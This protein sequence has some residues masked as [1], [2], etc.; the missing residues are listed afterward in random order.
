MQLV[1]DP[2]PDPLL[3]PAPEAVV[4]GRRRAV[5]AGDVV[6]GDAGAQHIEDAV[7]HPTVIGRLAALAGW[8]KQR[9]DDLPLAVRLVETHGRHAPLVAT[10]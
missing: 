1:E 6:P 5:P 7:E 9:L 2:L 8:R 10:T 4:D 3:R